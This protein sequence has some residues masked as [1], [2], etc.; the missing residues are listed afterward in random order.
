MSYSS[1]PDYDSLNENSSDIE[2]LDVVFKI[3]QKSHGSIWLQYSKLFIKE[4]DRKLFDAKLQQTGLVK[5][6]KSKMNPTYQL[7]D[8]GLLFL[9][10]HKSYSAYSEQLNKIISHQNNK[11]E[12][13]ENLE[14][15]NLR[16]QNALLL[17][18]LVD[19]PK[20]KA[21]KRTANIIAIISTLVSV[22]LLIVAIIQYQKCT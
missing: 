3:L 20:V 2:R 6:E 22:G 18:Q 21:Q 13:K 7:N 17:S 12:E 9:D 16:S 5:V 11:F 19:Y 8:D 4:A 14:L 15:E 10:K 1:N